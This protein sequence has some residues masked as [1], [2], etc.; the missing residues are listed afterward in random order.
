MS[1]SGYDAVVDIDDEVRELMRWP[2][3]VIAIERNTTITCIY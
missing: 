1:R 3:F 2:R